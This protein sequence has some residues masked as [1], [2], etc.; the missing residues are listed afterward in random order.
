MAVSDS[1]GSVLN[2]L[3]LSGSIGLER[4]SSDCMVVYLHG[5]RGPQG[6]FGSVMA[7]L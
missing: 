7:V 5:S 6:K 1:L 3:V 4:N 2:E